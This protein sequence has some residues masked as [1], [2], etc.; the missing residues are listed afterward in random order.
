MDYQITMDNLVLLMIEAKIVNPISPEAGGY[1]AASSSG[2]NSDPVYHGD[3]ATLESFLTLQ[4][5]ALPQP[6][7]DSPPTAEVEIS[8]RGDFSLPATE[9]RKME[10]CESTKLDISQRIANRMFPSIK[11]QAEDVLRLMGIGTV[12][13]PW[14]LSVES[15]VRE[16]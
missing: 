16:D 12:N 1:I 7:P 13:M 5:S 2:K 6:D 9:A 15:M 3:M 8:F 10:S 11:T 14:H 4:V